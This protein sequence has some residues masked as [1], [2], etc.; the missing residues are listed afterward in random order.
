[1]I[2]NF[3]LTIEYDGTRFHGWQRQK[4]LPTIQEAVRDAILA[5]TQQTVP[6]FGSGRTDAG[7]HALG[8]VASFACD[9]RLA[10]ATLQK[11]LNSLLDDDIVVTDCQE[12]PLDFHAQYSTKSKTYQYRI[13]NREIPAA[14][15]RRYAWHIKKPLEMKAMQAA[16][17]A[18]IG[19]HDFSS[20]EGVGSPRTSPERHVTE[21]S[22]TAQPG[23]YIVF[24]I[25]ADGFL[26]HMVRNI[27][28]TLVDV[29][30]GRTAP[31]AVAAILA[32]RDRSRAGATA[33]AHGLFLVR[34]CY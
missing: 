22:F 18:I 32:A 11:A 14:L 5:V 8:Q 2:R 9:T 28:G 4:G 24:E 23:G 29:G 3:K 19:R 17:P 34:V 12:V 27:V 7:V 21:A 25:T 10:P 13:L 16:L 6:V 33:P 1:M 15:C 26:K 20:F 30:L 31:E